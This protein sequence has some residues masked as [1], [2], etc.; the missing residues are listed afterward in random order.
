M[1][2]FDRFVKERNAAAHL[3]DGLFYLIGQLKGEED[4]AA[5]HVNNQLEALLDTHKKARAD[6]T[7]F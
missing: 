7:D 6:F 1:D 4:V 5:I 3:R 2:D